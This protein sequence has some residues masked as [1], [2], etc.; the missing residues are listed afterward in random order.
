MEERAK[1]VGILG[2]QCYMTEGTDSK[3]KTVDMF[4]KQ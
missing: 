4:R 3:T 1:E 2:R